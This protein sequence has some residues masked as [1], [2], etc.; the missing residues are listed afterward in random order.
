MEW[1]RQPFGGG[2]RGGRQPIPE[3]NGAVF[4]NDLQ[5]LPTGDYHY[6]P[7]PE[8]KSKSFKT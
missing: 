1:G 6:L 4:R 2:H 8:H 5:M 7:T 3:T